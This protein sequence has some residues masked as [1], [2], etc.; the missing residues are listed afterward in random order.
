[1]AEPSTQ[2]NAN[3]ACRSKH[4]SRIH[5]S[6]LS[7]LGDLYIPG[8]DRLPSFSQ[9]GC[10]HHLDIVLDGIHPDDLNAV[11]W[12]LAGLWL[13]P[14]WILR[15]LLSMMDQHD[16]Y[17]EWIATPLRLVS[18]AIKGLVM[19]LYYSGL[20]IDDSH[21]P[22]VLDRIGYSLHCEP[23]SADEEQPR[24]PAV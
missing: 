21:S 9:S 13:T 10:L 24:A 23:D 20:T 5:L 16:Q 22:T 3:R 7:R 15:K 6:S 8:T 17:S 4:L 12:L 1:M 11:R 18:L 19:S 14:K 2:Q